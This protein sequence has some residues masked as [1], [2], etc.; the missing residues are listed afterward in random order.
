MKSGV[1]RKGQIKISFGMIFS[2]ILIIVFLA[3][4]FYAI[5]TFLGIQS[6][7]TTGKFLHD[8]QA[9]VDRIWNS[10]QSSEQNEYFLPSRIEAVC[11]AD[12]SLPGDQQRID[13]Y[14]D[15]KR[16]YTGQENLVFSPRNAATPKSTEI[17]NID[18]GAIIAGENPY[19]IPV[20]NGRIQ[21]RFVKEFGEAQ[22]TI[23][24]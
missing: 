7:A 5:S 11:F 1:K 21:I 23:T 24:R 12:F 15:L 20:S 22:V 13:L 18:L 6:S 14:N 17:K 3:F 10:Q 2:I 16:E 9:D 8:L 19:C 4:G